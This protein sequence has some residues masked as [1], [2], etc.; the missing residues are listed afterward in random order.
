MSSTR[1]LVLGVVRIFQPVH[2]Y[3]VRRELLSWRLQ[4]WMNIQQGSIY[5]AL[6]TLEK[7]RLIEVVDDADPGGPESSRPPKRR[8]RVTGEGEKDFQA[9]LRSAWWQV[10]RAAEPLIPALCLMP[11]MPRTELIAALGS[12]I[13]QLRDEA[14][15][16]RF[17]RS[18]IRDGATGADGEVPDHVREILDFATSR[19]ASEIEWAKG[20]QQRLKAGMYWFADEGPVEPRRPGGPD[21]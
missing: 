17:Q 7:D 2:G 4:D 18:T 3:E 5:S 14:E 16:Y 19:I 11:F 21:T 20:L 8:Y 15:Q 13:N 6:K 9:Q 12:R 1:L 10:E